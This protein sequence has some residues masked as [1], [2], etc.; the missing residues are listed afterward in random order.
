MNKKEL[1]NSLKNFNFPENILNAFLKVDRSLFVP[2]ELM[3][4]S[5]KDV[6]L[7]I[8]YNQTISQPYTIAFMLTLLEVRNGQKILEIGSGSGYVLA[9]LAELNK[10]GKI[11]GVERIK[12]LAENSKEKLKKYKNARVIEGGTLH[13]LEN[14]KFDRIL[15]SASFKEIPQ[16]IINTNLKIKGIL[17][18]PVGNSIFVVK[19]DSGENK[20]KEYPGFSFVPMV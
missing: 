9:L 3:G 17:V 10:D 14:E 11:Y 15:A 8:G 18:A 13:K 19:K 2:P 6:A 12:E 4:E 16:K 1:I 7:P 5:Y 20:I